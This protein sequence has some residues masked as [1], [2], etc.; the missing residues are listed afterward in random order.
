M[1]KIDWAMFM[2]SVSVVDIYKYGT[3]YRVD[4]VWEHWNGRLQFSS[5]ISGCLQSRDRNAKH[6][7][8]MEGKVICFIPNEEFQ[9]H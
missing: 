2:P 5:T 9:Y 1:K 4:C 8:A 6:K 7:I 3:K